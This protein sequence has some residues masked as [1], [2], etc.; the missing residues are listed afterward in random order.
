MSFIEEI[1]IRAKENIKTIALPEASDVRILEATNTILKEGFAN[2][3]LIG[4]EDEI[5]KKARPYR[6]LIQKKA[7]KV[8]FYSFKL[9]IY[10]Q[11]VIAALKE[12]FHFF[13]R[14]LTGIRARASV[15]N[16]VLCDFRQFFK[17]YF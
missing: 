10:F 6:S 3:V 14:R 15:R 1:K 17:E 5:L 13:L 4:E 9:E 16:R 8:L 2:V 12:L 7:D 11:I